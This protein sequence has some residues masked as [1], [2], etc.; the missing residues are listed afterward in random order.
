M[1]VAVVDGRERRELE[2]VARLDLEDLQRQRASRGTAHVGQQVGGRQRQVLDHEIELIV[3]ILDPRDRDVSSFV[4]E[5]R[6]DDRPQVLPEM[7]FVL[8]IAVAVEEE[9][10]GELLPVVAELLVERVV[11]ELERQWSQ[12]V[13]GRTARVKSLIELNSSS[14]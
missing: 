2:V 13:A 10:L 7:R 3:S 6:Q 12:V 14:R 1:T 5:R 11:A 9:V 4:D 8:Q